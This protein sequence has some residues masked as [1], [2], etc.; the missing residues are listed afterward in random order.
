MHNFN[1]GCHREG[2]YPFKDPDHCGNYAITNYLYKRR[3]KFV[4][5]LD[6]TK[7]MVGLPVIRLIK[8]HAIPE[9][10]G[11]ILTVSCQLRIEDPTWIKRIFNFSGHYRFP[12]QRNKFRQYV[13]HLDPGIEVFIY[14]DL[15]AAPT[16]WHIG[17]T[18]RCPFVPDYSGYEHN[19]EAFIINQLW[20][21][22]A[23]KFRGRWLD[24]I[25][26]I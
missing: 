25:R 20:K 5:M 11:F 22:L 6:F 17:Y 14:N 19:K 9:P 8:R 1:E 15:I 18:I 12:L 2:L 10:D 16:R 23:T 4:R 26:Y 24:P 21:P 7:L 13:L 3:R